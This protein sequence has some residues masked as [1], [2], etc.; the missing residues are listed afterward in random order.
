MHALV[1]CRNI[2]VHIVLLVNV[3]VNCIISCVL[4]TFLYMYA[5]VNFK[6]CAHVYSANLKCGM[7][8]KVVPAEIVACC[9]GY[10]CPVREKY[11]T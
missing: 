10:T 4:C 8:V 3:H 7:R 1:N 5:I 2:H 11:Y 9:W 6:C